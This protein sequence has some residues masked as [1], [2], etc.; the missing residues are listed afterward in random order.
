MGSAHATTVPHCAAPG[1][2]RLRFSSETRLLASVRLAAI[3][4]LASVRLAADWEHSCLWEKNKQQHE[5]AGADEAH[6]AGRLH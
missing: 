5:N 6:R 4:L 3:R 1:L 2:T